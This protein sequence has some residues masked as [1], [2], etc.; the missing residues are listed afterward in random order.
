[1]LKM[2]EILMTK[3]ILWG[4]EHA[5]TIAVNSEYLPG[6]FILV[7]SYT[8][9]MYKISVGI[10]KHKLLCDTNHGRVKCVQNKIGIKMSHNRRKITLKI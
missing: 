1:M 5:S 8:I 6:C 3:N 4:F 9:V 10:N 7:I 2:P